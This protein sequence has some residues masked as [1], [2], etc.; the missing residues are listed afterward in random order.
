MA[1]VLIEETTMTSIGDS[2]RSKTGKTDLI[3]PA[4]MP[5][6]IDGI[7]TGIDTSDADA[8]ASDIVKDK[9]AYVNG[10]KIVGTL[11]NLLYVK[12][13]G[14]ITYDSDTLTS[15]SIDTGL[16]KI[17]SIMVYSQQTNAT[18]RTVGW[19]YCNDYNACIYT[20][21]Y[22]TLNF[23][24][25]VDKVSVLGGIA[26]CKQYDSTYYIKSGTY[27]WIAFGQ[28]E[29]GM[30]ST[31]ISKLIDIESDV[32]SFTFD[33]D[34]DN[35]CSITVYEQSEGTGNRTNRW[36]YSEVGENF[37]G[38]S[39]SLTSTNK[40]SID[41]GSVICNS[42]SNSY[43][44]KSGTYNVI[45]FGTKNTEGVDTSDATATKS[46][47]LSG[48]T[49]YVNGSKVTGTIYVNNSGNTYLP[50]TTNV[51]IPSGQYLSKSLTFKG[52]SNLLAENIKSGISIFNITG[53]YEGSGSGTDT[54][55]ATASA[56]DI[57]EGKTAYVNGEKVIGTHT[58]NASE[59]YSI[60]TGTTTSSIIETGLSSIKFIAIYKSSVSAT[61]L[62]QAVYLADNS[63][64]NYTYCSSYSSYYKTYAV[65][66]NT[67]S[68]VSGGTF[69]WGGSGTSGLSSGTTYNW[70]A[71]GNS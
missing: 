12:V 61:G 67:S 55:D 42:Y 21:D 20:G 1:N 54:S 30:T 44:I 18:G 65:G 26:L 6:E 45:A 5:E 27:S 69:T 41:G 66:T 38:T 40:V 15:I 58:C 9:T 34:L 7:T 49:A 19:F 16:K 62:V 11:E 57:V 22:Q 48:K 71:F 70:I 59:G 23:R 8:I 50:G 33:T 24:S 25:F 28:K 53:T 3:L 4:N 29:T 39:N 64:A 35:I 13:F 60:A 37:V 68:T 47:I 52:D 10:E 14:E 2:I 32:S 56:S 17:D 36:I 63:N 51:T 46:D 43:L 31:K